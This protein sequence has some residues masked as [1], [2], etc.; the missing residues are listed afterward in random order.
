M[1]GYSLTGRLFSIWIDC[2]YMRKGQILSSWGQCPINS[3]QQTK[4]CLVCE[5][6]FQG[7]WTT[8][9]LGGHHSDRRKKT[10]EAESHAVFSAG[11]EELNG[12]KSPCVWL[13]T[14][15]W[16]VANGLAIWSGRRAMEIWLT[17]GMHMWG[18]ALWK[19]EGCIKVCHFDAHQKNP[20]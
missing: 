13:F 10:E 12:R 20:F 3:S 5:W 6:H 16:E 17:K 9:S 8:S 4:S 1:Q 7:E 19:F 15:L 18:T 11:L 14:G 2:N